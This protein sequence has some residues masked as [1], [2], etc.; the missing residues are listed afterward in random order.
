MTYFFET[1]GCEMNIAE[2]ASVEQIFIARGW[3]KA[4]CCEEADVVI[5]NTCSVRATAETRIFGRLGFY[6]GLKKVRLGEKDAKSRSDE[7]KKAAEF[8]QKNGVRPLTLIVMGCMAERL[9]NSLKKDFPVVDYVVGTYAKNKFGN[10]ITAVEEG[11][12]PVQIE[13]EPVYVFAETSYE[14]GAFSTFVPIMHG[15]NNFCSYC[16]VPYVR[17]REV[18]RPVN[19]ILHELDVLS[20]RGVKEITLLGQNVNS[21]AGTGPDSEKV[22][23]P[24]LL[25]IITVHL[26]KIDSSIKWI[27]FE[28]S[29]PKDFSDELIDVIAEN[30][31]VC[32]GLH[33][34]V[35]HGSTEILKRMNRKY[36]R[37]VYLE[38]VKKIKARISEAA[39]STDIMIGFPGETDEQFNE[40]LTLMEEVRY[41]SAFMY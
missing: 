40:V 36:S 17:G 24:G 30:P 6:A 15:C 7:M 34:A 25:K 26:E 23:F 19:E 10:I 27:R 31:Y 14:E 22:S 4:S 8:V 35:Q 28:S 3:T 32:K 9:L 2:S 20:L 37:E 29:N 18:S 39:L 11:Q 12:K 21:Y 33:V 5:I 41:S 16:I 1:Y 13:E 38:L